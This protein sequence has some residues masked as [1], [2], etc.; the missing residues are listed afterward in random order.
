MTATSLMLEHY[1]RAT[2]IRLF[3][4]S[5][6]VNLNAATQG[7]IRVGILVALANDLACCVLF[8]PLLRCASRR[9][10]SSRANSTRRSLRRCNSM[11]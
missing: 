4:S 10:S 11:R 8:G 5:F 7:V 9:R 6:G 2:S 3:A 1:N